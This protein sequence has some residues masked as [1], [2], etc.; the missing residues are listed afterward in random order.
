ME[1]KLIEIMNMKVHLIQFVSIVK[2]IK[3]TYNITNTGPDRKARIREERTLEGS[4]RIWHF[5]TQ[6]ERL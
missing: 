3:V 2:L 4:G 1:S 5:L 6:K